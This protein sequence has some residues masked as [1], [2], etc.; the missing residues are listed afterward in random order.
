[1]ELHSSATSGFI[2]EGSLLDWA[3]SAEGTMSWRMAAA[4]QRLLLVSAA[5]WRESAI[6]ISGR[7]PCSK[8][9]RPRRR[10]I[11]SEEGSEW[12]AALASWRPCL[13]DAEASVG[14]TSELA[15]DRYRALASAWLAKESCL[16]EGSQV[17]MSLTIILGIMSG[18]R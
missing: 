18:D 14:D 8:R 1:M 6:E 17:T 9:M 16:S 7:L 13:S 10:W 4:W 11:E 5:R 2:R 15:T 3:G 12:E